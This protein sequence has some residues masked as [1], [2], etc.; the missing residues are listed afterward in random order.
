MKKGKKLLVDL[1][2]IKELCGGLGQVSLAYGNYFKAHYAGKSSGYQ[3]YLLLPK[4]Y[5]GAFGK[6]IKYISSDN[7]FRRHSRYFFPNV[8]VWHAIYQISRFKPYSSKTKFILTIHDLNYLYEAD[9]EKSKYKSQYRTQRKVNRADEIVCI[10]HF[11][12]KEV[13]ENLVLNGKECKVIYNQV[14]TFDKSLA[15]KPNREIK[16]PF[17]FAIGVIWQK[18]NFHV[19]LDLMKRMPDKHLYIAGK[20]RAR[21]KDN[22]YAIMIRERLRAENIDNVTLMGGISDAEKIWMYENCEAFL[23]PSLLEGF[24]LPVIEA[25]QFGKPVFS[26]SATSLPEIGDKYAFFWPDFEPDNMKKLIEETLPRFYADEKF[27]EEQK[28]YAASFSGDRHFEEYEKLY[29]NLMD[30]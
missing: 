30:I 8:D 11:V 24:G 16:T 22:G 15:E 19:L 17:F 3:L 29:R 5:F 10:S 13:E 2:E 23:V 9:S 14:K 12:K 1:S 26:S 27:M 18:K 20:E 6:Q 7:W 21:E 4:K 28:R 25:M